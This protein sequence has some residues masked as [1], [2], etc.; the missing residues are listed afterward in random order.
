[1]IYAIRVILILTMF[2]YPRA[3]YY[4]VL[5]I[6]IQLILSLNSITIKVSHG[7]YMYFINYMYIV[8]FQQD[9]PL[10]CTMQIFKHDKVCYGKSMSMV[11]RWWG[12]WVGVETP[13]VA[14]TISWL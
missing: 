7:K 11:Y 6:V 5:L 13:I 2:G 8:T 14:T 12:V 9:L 10:F 1:L 4:I 3:R